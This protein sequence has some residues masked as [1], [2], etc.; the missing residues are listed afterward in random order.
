MIDFCDRNRG[1]ASHEKSVSPIAF[2]SYLCM[3]FPILYHSWMKLSTHIQFF[4]EFSLKFNI[5]FYRDL[6][7]FGCYFHFPVFHEKSRLCT[8]LQ[9]PAFLVTT[10]RTAALVLFFGNGIE[11]GF[12]CRNIELMPNINIVIRVQF[13]NQQRQ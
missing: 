13:L 1:I 11:V 9:E 5:C 10:A 7:N 8:V 2:L 3:E 12:P 6:T 4:S